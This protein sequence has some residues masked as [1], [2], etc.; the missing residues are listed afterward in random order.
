MTTAKI[1][2][3]GQVTIPKK[4]RKLL[5]GDVIQFEVVKGKVIIKPVKSVAGSLKNYVK[6]YIPLDKVREKIWSEV[7]DEKTT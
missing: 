6:K 1:T 2:R 4:I 3:K 5:D 7:A